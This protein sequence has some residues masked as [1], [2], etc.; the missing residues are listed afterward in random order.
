ML[1]DKGTVALVTGAS[2]GIGRAIAI[3]LARE[4]AHVVVNYNTNGAAAE[5]VVETIEAEGGTAEAWQVDLAD[6][7]Q[8]KAMF[9]KV[10]FDLGR[11]DVLV[12]NAGI[13]NDGFVMMMSAEKFESVLRTNLTA[14]FFTC[15][16]ALKLMAKAGS[17]SIVNISSVSGIAGA[18]GQLNYSAAKGG[19]I[20]FSKGLAREAAPH[21]VRVNVVAPGLIDTDMTKRV[22]LEWKMTMQQLI[23]LR[24]PGRPDEVASL[25]SFLASP[26]ASYITG[27]VFRVDG[28]LVVG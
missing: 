13:I 26:K 5:E 21:D 14:V 20:A 1:F 8:V 22:P 12:N 7:K 23:P 11:L 10:R 28:G 17:G 6:E 4:G 25:V 19:V 3:D 9:R 27:S 16:D 2:R 15:R 18:E 24:R